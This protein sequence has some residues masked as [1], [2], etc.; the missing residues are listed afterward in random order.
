MEHIENGTSATEYTTTNNWNN[1]DQLQNQYRQH[2]NA[3]KLVDMPIKKETMAYLIAGHGGETTYSTEK[4]KEAQEKRN[5]K[6]KET[7]TVPPGCTIVVHKHPYELSYEFYDMTKKLMSLPKEVINNPLQHKYEIIKTLGSVVFYEAGEEC[8]YFKYTTVDCFPSE[9]PYKRC[10]GRIGSGVNN[11]MEMKDEYDRTN[12]SRI[13]KNRYKD[14]DIKY[15]I[16]EL[17]SEKINKLK[18]NE[19]INI[20]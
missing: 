14:T 7:F 15:D 8:P 3:R 17:E 19:V 18:M 9:Q 16:L 5:K 12:I 13:R 6:Q 11:L 2:R 10:Y 4:T 20:I 1:L